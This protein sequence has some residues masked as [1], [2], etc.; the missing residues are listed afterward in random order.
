[1]SGETVRRVGFVGL[2]SQGAPMAHRIIEAG[3]PTT[4]WARRP[5]TLKPFAG[6][7]AD[8]AGSAAELGAACDLAC[9]CVLDD[10]GVEQVVAGPA[11]LLEGMRP[12]GVIAVHSTVH[13]DTCRRLAVQAAERGVTLIDAPVSGGGPA[14]EKGS[15]LVMIGGEDAAVERS[16]PVFETY[17]DPVVHLG[18]VGAGQRA[19]L[20]N[21]LLLAANLGVAESAFALARGLDI[22]PAQLSVVLAHGSGSSFAAGIMRQPDFSLAS[23]AGITGPLL[24]KDARIVVALAEASGVAAGTVL[25]AADAALESMGCPR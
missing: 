13:P 25:G 18:P 12:G 5:E 24:Q 23:M 20:I 8:T 17:G 21:N 6:T 7:P 4:L 9:V 1:M 10:D 3:V 14:A 16:R 2:G 15:L 19:K 11:G 22:D